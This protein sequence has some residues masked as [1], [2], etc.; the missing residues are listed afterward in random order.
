MGA[1]GSPCCPAEAGR[2][3]SPA[4]SPAAGRRLRRLRV[5][6][7]TPPLPPRQLPPWQALLQQPLPPWVRGL[8]LLLRSLL[9][10]RGGDGDL[11]LPPQ[12]PPS[13]L[14]PAPRSTSC[15]RCGSG[16]DLD[17]RT[18]LRPPPPSL[19]SES[20]RRPITGRPSRTRASS[21]SSGRQSRLP[22]PSYN[23]LAQDIEAA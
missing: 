21:R 9:S 11:S 20:R 4:P 15:A 1:G 18:W 7:P 13:P 19:A 5:P 23:Q 17:G 2:A 10:T 22:P 14:W 6:R 3:C 16:R 12:P 8:L